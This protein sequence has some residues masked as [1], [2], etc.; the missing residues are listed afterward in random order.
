MGIQIDDLLTFLWTGRKEMQ[1][2]R[3]VLGSLVREVV[4]ECARAEHGRD[5]LWDI[6]SFP[7]VQGDPAMLRVVLTHLID[8]AVKYTRARTPAQITIDC[9]AVTAHEVVW[10]VRDNGIGFDMQYA[11]KIF[12]V[13]HR[14]HHTR[15]ICR[16]RN[17]ACDR[18]SHHPAPWRWHLGGSSG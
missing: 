3:I 2:T 8:N 15:G 7:A 9:A 14:L 10:F 16:G 6:G 5:I 18:A 17:R 11:D 12:A 13:F 1:Q 4:H